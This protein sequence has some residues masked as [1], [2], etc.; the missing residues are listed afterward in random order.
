MAKLQTISWAEIVFDNPRKRNIWSVFQR[1][2][3]WLVHE[4]YFEERGRSVHLGHRIVKVS[5]FLSF[6]C[7]I[8][9]KSAI[10]PFRCQSSFFARYEELG[11]LSLCYQ[12]CEGELTENLGQ[13]LP[14]YF[15]SPYYITI[16]FQGVPAPGHYQI[17]SQ[18]EHEKVVPE[19]SHTALVA[20]FGSQARVWHK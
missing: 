2:W 15:T 10:I 19:T 9:S 1:K 8:P 5:D 17:K 6:R 4:N 18:F 12:H 13:K 7:Q 3:V 16:S 20:P 14:S 11:S